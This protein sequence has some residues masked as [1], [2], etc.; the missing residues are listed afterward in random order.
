MKSVLFLCFTLASCAP[1]T[2]GF[3][4][5]NEPAKSKPSIR[6]H[7]VPGTT[8]GNVALQVATIEA[9]KDAF[10]DKAA[11]PDCSPAQMKVSD[12]WPLGNPAPSKHSDAF[13]RWEE[14]WSF[15][16]CG[17]SINAEIVYML[18]RNS[19]IIDVKVSPASDGQALG[20]GWDLLSFDI[21]LSDS[22]S[23]V[24]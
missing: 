21:E 23:G 5:T 15:E 7:L 24:A 14:L 12:T 1:Q 16:G 17:N 11:V 22:H 20:F 18:H 2:E 13:L 4:Q 9:A 8:Y 19:G 10:A 3:V 6:S